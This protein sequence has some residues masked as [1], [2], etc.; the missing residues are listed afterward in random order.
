MKGLGLYIAKSDRITSCFVNTRTYLVLTWEAALRWPG[1]SL[2][3]LLDCT[4]PPKQPWS[5]NLL[6]FVSLD[7][8][9]FLI[10]LRSRLIHVVDDRSN[11]KWKSFQNIRFFLLVVKIK[12]MEI[13]GWYCSIYNRYFLRALM[14]HSRCMSLSPGDRHTTHLNESQ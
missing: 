2:Q 4:V 1:I 6:N 13:L 8:I 5:H 3:Y 14:G 7:P 9:W 12:R 10:I 11:P